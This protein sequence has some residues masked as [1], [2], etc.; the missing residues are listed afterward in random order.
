MFKKTLL[1]ALVASIFYNTANCQITKG[2]WL[3]GGSASFERQRENMQG[4]EFIGRDLNLVP[5]IGYFVADKF[6]AGIKASL[7][8]NRIK[9]NQ[10]IV[11]NSTNLGF[12]PFFRYYFL[13][14]DSRVNIFS[15]AAYKYSI[16]FH[17]HEQSEFDFATGPALFFNSS[18][19]LELTAN[20]SYIKGT[21]SNVT[22]KAI[23]FAIGFQ[24]HLEKL[25]QN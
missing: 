8:Y 14:V 17:T 2:N 10:E 12:G 3:V 9:R 22:D 1:A 15:E 7:Y 16:D 21:I 19:G 5:N 20:Y 25:E 24:V 4:T 13:P 11:T 18:V 6:A 23:L